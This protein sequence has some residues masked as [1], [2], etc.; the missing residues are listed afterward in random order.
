MQ[1]TDGIDDGD[2]GAGGVS[3]SDSGSSG[4]RRALASSGK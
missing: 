3:P 4:R 2:D 1:E